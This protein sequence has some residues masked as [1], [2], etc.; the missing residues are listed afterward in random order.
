MI[1]LILCFYIRNH[2]IM[3]RQMI[4]SLFIDLITNIIIVWL[5]GISINHL[6]FI[7]LQLESLCNMSPSLLASVGLMVMSS[8][9]VGWQ[10]MLVQWLERRPDNDKDLLTGAC[11]LIVSDFTN[12]WY[13]SKMKYLPFHWQYWMQAITI[14][15]TTN[16]SEQ[17]EYWFILGYI[18][19]NVSMSDT[20]TIIIKV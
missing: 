3:F 15:I 9:D 17:S 20:A 1:F 19:R 7:C 13:N 10:L 18:G 11:K 12:V 5:R 14:I 6:L 2:V 4:T 8:T 16:S